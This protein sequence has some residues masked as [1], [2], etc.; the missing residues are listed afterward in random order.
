[1][2]LDREYKSQ[3]RLRRDKDEVLFGSYEN[4]CAYRE[5]IR[6]EEEGRKRYASEIT[7]HEF[8]E[9]LRDALGPLGPVRP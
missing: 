3:T 4:G 9:D 6:G 7:K 8:E 1:M 5:F 2:L